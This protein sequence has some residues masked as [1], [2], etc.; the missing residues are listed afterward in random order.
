MRF[1]VPPETLRPDG[2]ITQRIR[3][4]EF[5]PVGPATEKARTCQMCCDETAEYYR[6]AMFGRRAFSIA[7]PM[8]WNSLPDSLRDPARR[9]VARI[10]SLGE[11][12]FSVWGE[13]Y[14]EYYYTAIEC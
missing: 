1:Q 10:V 12:S 8:E 6:S 11:G 5:Q 14:F 4:F 7:G 13:T 9:Y 2:L 3:P